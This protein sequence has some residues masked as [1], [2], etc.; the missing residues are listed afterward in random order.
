MRQRALAGQILLV[1]CLIGAAGCGGGGGGTDGS[2]PPIAAK[3]RGDAIT[4]NAANARTEIVVG[5]KSFT[6]QRVLGQ[7]FAQ[8][9]GAAGYRV[10]AR[11]DL[12]NERRAL[13][14]LRS[15]SIDG[16]PEYTGTALV[17]FCRADAQTIPKD[18]SLAFRDARAC[19]RRMG[20]TAFPP[21]PFTTSLEVAVPAATA[22]RLGLRTISDL[23]PHGQ[24]FVFYG[25]PECRLRTDCLLGLRNVYGARFR[26]FAGVDPVERHDVL[27]RRPDAVSIVYATDPQIKREPIVLLDD[28]RGMF[29]PYNSTFVVRDD[30]VK[31]AGPD[32]PRVIG[33]VQPGLTDEVMQ[34]LNARVDIDKETPSAVA[35]SYLRQSGLLPPM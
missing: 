24:E 21:T 33:K 22:D 3:R 15:G 20:L 12:E 30:V 23:V 19:L 16:Y 13:K 17:S 27:L 7:I 18:P 29:P 35:L 32:L 2:D 9:L 8:A 14:R 4:R 6:E 5:S 1:L 10:S 25:T 34:E 31:Q 28:D 26:R 11:L